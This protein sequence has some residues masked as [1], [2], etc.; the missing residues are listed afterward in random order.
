[1]G[2]IASRAEPPRFQ[3][4]SLPGRGD[5]GTAVPPDRFPQLAPVLPFGAGRSYG[6]GCMLTG[7][8]LIDSRPG[9][10]VHT[11]DPIAGLVTADAGISL[12]ELMEHVA[13][14]HALNVVPGTQFAT[15]GGAIAN[16]VHGRNHRRRGSFGAHVET[17]VLRRS[18]HGRLTLSPGDRL[19]DATVG[20]MGLTG[21]IEQATIRVR[22][23]SSTTIRRKTVRFSSLGDY[24]ARIEEAEARHEYVVAWIDGLA[25]NRALGGGH[26]VTGD[27]AEVAGRP[28]MPWRGPRVAVPFTPPLS[29]WSRP[30][31]RLL[32]A[33]RLRRMAVGGETRSLPQHGF[34]FPLDAVGEWNRLYGR[35]GL[36]QHQSVVPDDAAAEAVAA[37]LRLTQH[38]RHDSVLTV[39]K[40][41]GASRSP[42]MMSFARPGLALTMHFPD[43]GFATA[44]LLTALDRIV[45]A[46]GGAINP[47]QD[48]RMAAETFAMAMPR[49]REVEA[50]RDPAIVSDFWRRT[51]LRLDE[52]PVANGSPRWRSGD[53]G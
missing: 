53:H 44:K 14:S 2:D 39:L 33:L 31:L 30:T 43:R 24:F 37:A 46:A 21:L 9:A 52:A 42:A 11:F 16:D 8:T 28:R 15:L 49:W 1:M 38:Q 13:P 26:L 25:R 41:F 23:V 7:G 22:G 47:C 17:I 45:I 6:D 40:R 27:H 51:A 48:R 19:F 34:F 20:G 3:P 36:H 5:P 10:R 32:N 18:D 50:L 4:W 35:R 12:G 29:A